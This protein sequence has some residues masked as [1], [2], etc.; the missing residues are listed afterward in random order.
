MKVTILGCG[1]SGGVPLIGCGC[2]VCQ[3]ADPKNTRTRNSI[4]IET[5]GQT[6]LVDTSPDLR[7]QALRENLSHIDAV[8]YTHTH[9]D[10]TNGIDDMRAFNY[11]RN[12][13]IPIYGTEEI[14]AQLEHQFGYALKPPAHPGRWNR[15]SLLPNMIQEYDEFQIGGVQIKSFLQYHGKGKSLGYR[16]DNVAYSTDVNNLPEQSL[17]LLESLDV[18]VVDCL[19]YEEAATHAHLAMTLGWIERLKPKRA[20]LTHMAHELEYYQLSS[21]LPAGIEP[22]YDGMSITL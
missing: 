12:A 3:S 5:G 17:Q 13:S 4:V 14:L 22:A 9:A 6:L 18:W 21:E 2:T 10:H 16:I 7:Q 15:P 20:I 11:H 8:L 1:A 19:R